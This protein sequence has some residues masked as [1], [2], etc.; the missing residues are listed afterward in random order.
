MSPFNCALL[1]IG[2]YRPLLRLLVQNFRYTWVLSKVKQPVKHQQPGVTR[3]ISQL[4]FEI[5]CS[6]LSVRMVT[7]MVE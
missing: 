7:S 3:C 4:H 2:C 6:F 5:F 1:R